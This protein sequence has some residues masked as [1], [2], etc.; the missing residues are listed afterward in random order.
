MGV[1]WQRRGQRYLVAIAVGGRRRYTTV[2]SEAD[3]KALQRE[4]SRHLIAGSDIIAQIDKARERTK[5]S[6]FPR[7]RDALPG[8]RGPR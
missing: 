5:P 7:L 1:S 2:S 4:F 3:A 8:P 6:T